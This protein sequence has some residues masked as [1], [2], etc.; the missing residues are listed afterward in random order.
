MF[1]DLRRVAVLTGP[2]GSGKTELAI[3]LA[4]EMSADLILLDERDGR[5]AA[6]GFLAGH[7]GAF[8]ATLDDA[9]LE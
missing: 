1:P 6:E 9:G 7:R 3:A 8:F 2:Y 5:A 4:L